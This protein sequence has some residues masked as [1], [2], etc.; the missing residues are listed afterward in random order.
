MPFYIGSSKLAR[1][2]HGDTRIQ[3]IYRGDELVFA[4]VLDLPTQ[5]PIPTTIT[6]QTQVATAVGA[7]YTIYNVQETGFYKVICQAGSGGSTPLNENNNFAG[8][9]TQIVYLYRGTKC[10][11]WGATR[12]YA[13][14]SGD[15]LPGYTGYPSPTNT[16][17]STG[18]NRTLNSSGG[19]G[20][21]A[22]NN[23]L[24]GTSGGGSGGGGAGFLAGTDYPVTYL[25]YKNNSW[26][27]GVSTNESWTAGDFSV[28][29]L[30][31]RILCGGAG[32]NSPND[33]NYSAGG[34][35]GGAWGNSGWAYD[36]A[37][38]IGIGGEWGQGG[39]STLYSV[40]GSGAWCIMDFS[41][42][43]WSW[44]RGGGDGV[45]TDGYCTLYKIS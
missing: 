40:G 14:E 45:D 4:G 35:G 31:C 20:G 39:N 17:G 2:Y 15:K 8:K 19:P 9:T 10:L 5:N 36:W 21:G 38:T 3:F 7:T 12:G 6:T 27:Q 37:P 24:Y 1:I 32:G 28:Q 43:Q 29:H 41:C 26:S 42:N 25:T 33:G 18:P 22:A 16:L 44:G 13:G 34:A 11:L 30:Y 23:G